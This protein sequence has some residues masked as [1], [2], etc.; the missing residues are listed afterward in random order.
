VFE[1]RVHGG[2]ENS[3]LNMNNLNLF[4]TE[5]KCFCSRCGAR[6]KVDPKAGSKSRML[7]CGSEP[8]GLCINCAVHDTL[9]HLYPAN[10][11]L[12]SS[13]PRC[14]AVP[15][16]QEQFAGILE[17][18]NSDARPGE[19]SWNLII[20]NW[21]LPFR[22]KLKRTATNPVSQEDLDRE[23]E[24]RKRREAML[25]EPYKTPEQIEEE[26]DKKL[27]DFINDEFLPLMRKLNED[28]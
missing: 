26:H 22:H 10:L 7:K 14:L 2:Q 13:G 6:C 17:A 23:P 4:E 3:G 11:L 9:R 27:N 8:K 25:R 1:L 21:D 15:Q 24:E 12:A 16:I 5:Q 18:H 28:I 19:I 20:D